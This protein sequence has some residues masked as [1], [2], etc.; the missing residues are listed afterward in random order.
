VISQIARTILGIGPYYYV[1]QFTTAVLLVLAAN[2]AFADFPR[3]AYFMA[4]DKFLP[5]HFAFRGERLAFN[6]GIIVLAAVAAV[7]IVV[8]RGSVTALI[9]LYTIGVFVAFTL[10]QT[11]CCPRSP[12]SE[13][14][15]LGAA[16]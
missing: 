6:N 4:R 13:P 11:V 2:T 7:L 10:S 14:G 8:F 12:A 1:L 5:S 16:R 15:W 9:P 3:L